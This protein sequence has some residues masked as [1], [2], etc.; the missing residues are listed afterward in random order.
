[1]YWDFKEFCRK[2]QRGEEVMKGQLL[3]AGGELGRQADGNKGDRL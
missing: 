2:I 3:V 1:M